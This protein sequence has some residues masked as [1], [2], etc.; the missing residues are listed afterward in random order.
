MHGAQAKAARKEAKDKEKKKEKKEKTDKK[1]I[2]ETKEKEKKEKRDK[3]DTKDTHPDKKERT[4]KCSDK[5]SLSETRWWSVMGRTRAIEIIWCQPRVS[6]P[7]CEVCAM[8]CIGDVL[9]D[10]R[11]GWGCSLTRKPVGLISLPLS[12][13][14]QT[15]HCFNRFR[16]CVVVQPSETLMCL[17]GIIVCGMHKKPVLAVFLA[18][19]RFCHGCADASPN[20]CTQR[21]PVSAGHPKS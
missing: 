6:K 11:L 15:K 7:V 8:C 20:P 12:A 5:E 17:L 3:K 18:V 9:A 4:K 13:S 1:E 14:Q 16:S 21:R 19:G 2:K 10:G